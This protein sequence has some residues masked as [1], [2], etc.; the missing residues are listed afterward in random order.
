MTD[1]FGFFTLTSTQ[2]TIA[3]SIYVLPKVHYIP[4]FSSVQGNVEEKVSV[5]GQRGMLEDYTEIESIDEYQPGVPLKKIHW[6][7]TASKDKL[8]VKEF[9]HPN[10]LSVLMY[11]D[12]ET[13]HYKDEDKLTAKDIV[14]E[15][16]LSLAYYVV[17]KNITC[18]VMMNDPAMTDRTLTNKQEF[19]QFYDYMSVLDMDQS[20]SFESMVRNYYTRNFASRDVIIVSGSLSEDLTDLIVELKTAGINVILVTPLLGTPEQKTKYSTGIEILRNKKIIVFAL[21]TADEIGTVLQS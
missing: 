3:N 8:L 12:I 6:K 16:A 18:K 20:L 1:Y 19:D 4:R 11:V 17:N 13:G 21:S 15:S 5:S 2:K 9:T 14:L 10:D 7:A